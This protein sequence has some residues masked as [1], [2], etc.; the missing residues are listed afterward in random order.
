MTKRSKASKLK[1]THSPNES[2]GGGEPSGGASGGRYASRGYLKLEAALQAFDLDPTGHRCADLGCSHGGFTDCLLRHG[3]QTVYAVDTAYGQLDYR[4]RT[5]PRVVV[6]ER[7][8][9][10][11]ADPPPDAAQQCDLVVLDLGWTKQD[12][13]VPAALRWLSREPHAR[14]I[15]LVKPHYETGEH[16][17]TDDQARQASEQVAREVLPTLGVE[18]LGLIDSPIPGGKGG[19]LE[20]LALLKRYDT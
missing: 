9:A 5:D 8:N 2:S 3:A 19:N 15:T 13:A 1:S 7:T 12:K 18:V 17:L 11:H 4:L 10:L 14:I 20:Q 16:R 6:L